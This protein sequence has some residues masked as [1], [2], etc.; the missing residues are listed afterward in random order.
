MGRLGSE[1][2]SEKRKKEER[3]G[4]RTVGEKER[5]IKYYGSRKGRQSEDN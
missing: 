1:G 5:G 3:W 2:E 4:N